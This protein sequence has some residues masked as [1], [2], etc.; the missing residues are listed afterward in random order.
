MISKL[1]KRVIHNKLPRLEINKLL[2]SDSKH[3]RFV[4]HTASVAT[5]ELCRCSAKAAIGSMCIRSIA[6]FQKKKKKLY[7]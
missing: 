2:R 4:G 7:L 1:K 6:I 3:F 5:T